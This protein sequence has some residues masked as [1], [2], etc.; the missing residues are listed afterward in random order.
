MSWLKSTPNREVLFK[1]MR[2]E[3]TWRCPPDGWISLG[4]MSGTSVDGLD[5]A[6]VRFRREEGLPPENQ[7]DFEVLKHSTEPYPES[8]R[9]QLWH[10]M[11]LSAESLHRLDRQWSLWVAT[12]AK[13]W[14]AS[15]DLPR[16]DLL[17]SHG[18][19]VFHRPEE[20]WTYQLGCGATLHAALGIP[21]VNDFRRLDVAHGGQGAPLVPMADELLF[22]QW[23]VALNLGGFANLSLKQPQHGR[24]AWDVGPANLLLNNLVSEV[25]LTMDANG[26]LARSGAVIEPLLQGCKSIAYHDLDPPKS[27]GREWLESAVLPLFAQHGNERLEDRLATAVEYIAWCVVRDVPK[28]ARI[29]VTGGGA[30]NGALMDALRRQGSEKGMTFHVPSP[31]L[32]DGKEAIAFAFLG[33]LRWLGMPN[34]MPSWTGASVPSSGGAMWGGHG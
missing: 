8:M 14:L 5:L 21:V 17:A 32:V 34:T 9:E 1:P 3:D 24:M 10:V 31:Q 18:H 6:L 25:D 7:W 28:Q 30:H 22:G 19:T 23:D 33:L 29:L 20:G 15:S 11:E 2:G 26:D 13:Q 27:T 4:I 12:E 16:P